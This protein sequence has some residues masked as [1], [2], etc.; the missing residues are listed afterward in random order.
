[1]YDVAV[2][3]AGPGGYA[4][5]LKAADLGAKVCI[6]EK[7]FPGGT[8]LNW[9]C[10]P[11][12]AILS[13]VKLLSAIKNAGEFGIDVKDFHIDIAKVLKRKN[14][15][16]L[17]LREGLE[18][19][20]KSKRID[21]IS[22]QAQFHDANTVEVNGNSISSKYIIIATG[23]SPIELGNLKFGHERIVSSKDILA[24]DKIPESIAIIGGGVIGCEFAFIYNQLGSK[25][26]IIEAL[27]QI[28]PNEDREVARRLESNFKKSGIDIIKGSRVVNIEG[29]GNTKI[30]LENNSCV[31][32]E[33]ALL[34]IG[35]KPYTDGLNLDAVGIKTEKNNIIV[36]NTLKTNI[37]NIYAIGDVIGGY[38]LAHVASYEGALASENIFGNPSAVDYSSV[39]SC[40]FTHPEIAS[41]GISEEKAKKSGIE[42][43][44]TKFP[45]TALGKAHVI[46]E[47]EGFIK[48]ISG[49]KTDKILGVHIFGALA[50]ELI[51]DFSIAMKNNIGAKELGKAIYAHPTLSEAIL[52]LAHRIK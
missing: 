33:I 16:V 28:L 43:T 22:G 44:V 37:N 21:L 1:M 50:S 24:L 20:F 51:A 45:F 26:T 18:L 48:L 11:T 23:S 7:D 29:N 42:F 2:L 12:K 34:C 40:I 13:S 8:C 49:T 5:A 38:H 14:D 32:T 25:V 4:A 35:R 41:I 19:L 47:T 10:I 30:N 6:I 17:K 3:G 15:I 9:G 36:D 39:P 46:G 52:E 27:E 31:E